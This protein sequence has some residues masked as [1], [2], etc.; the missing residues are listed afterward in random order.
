MNTTS[1]L[2]VKG[3][4]PTIGFIPEGATGNRL[5]RLK[6][7]SEWQA[8]TGRDWTRPDLGEYRDHLLGREMAPRSVKSVLSTIRKRYKEIVTNNGTRDLF[9]QMA[10]ERIAQLGTPDTPAERKAIVDEIHVRLAN[11]T[12]PE[13]SRVKVEVVQDRVDSAVGLRL[14]RDQASTLLATPGVVPILALRDTAILA[15]FLCTGI[16]VAELC[17]LNV[18]DLRQT[19]DGKLCL[20]VTRGK[21]DKTRAV[22]WGAGEWALQ[23]IDK[24]LVRAGI[25]EGA[26]FRGFYKGCHRLRGRISVR[27]VQKVAEKYNPQVIDGKLTDVHVHDLRRT[28]ARRCYDEGMAIVAIQQNLGHADH[29]TTAGY[30]GVLDSEQRAPPSLYSPPHWKALN[31]LADVG[32]MADLVEQSEID[33]EGV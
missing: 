30:I 29:K 7:F 14:T 10:A 24:W 3:H 6:L 18:D 32:V 25:T 22:P 31:E 28:Y 5:S 19:L 1:E 13:N 15:T 4:V 17:A 20:R 23:V 27:A 9:Y 21:G 26:V 16:R 12:N 8:D 2:T 33:G 11:A